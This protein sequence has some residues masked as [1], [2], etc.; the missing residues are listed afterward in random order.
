[1]KTPLRSIRKLSLHY[2]AIGSRVAAELGHLLLAEPGRIHQCVGDLGQAD[3][4]G[5][6]L[7]LINM[8]RS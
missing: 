7:D 8:A 6:P 5:P 1:M 3:A 4:H 2:R